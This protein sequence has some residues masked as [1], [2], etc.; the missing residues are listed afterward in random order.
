MKII[1]HSFFLFVALFCLAA[2]EYSNFPSWPVMDTQGYDTVDCSGWDIPA[3]AITVREALRIGKELG[4]GNTSEETYYIKGIVT[5]FH[6]KHESAMQDYGNAQFY[7]QDNLTFKAQFYA[8][9]IYGIDGVKFDSLSQV[10]VG[11]FVVIKSKITNYSGTIETTSKG[12]AS[13]AFSTNEYA[14]PWKEYYYFQE[15]FEKGLGQWNEQVKSGDITTIWKAITEGTTNAQADSTGLSCESW[16]VSPE[17]NVGTSHKNAVNLIFSH[18]FRAKRSQDKAPDYLRVK[19]R[20]S[21][22]EWNDMA[23][24]NFGTGKRTSYMKDTLDLS[25]YANGK[26]QIAFAY[27]SDADFQAQWNVTGISVSEYKRGK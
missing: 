7:I 10:Q 20:N 14:Y 22:G 24:H 21:A 13:M 16:L 19:V 1:K 17:I 9:Q 4:A 26:I 6:S 5:E 2:C 8:Y 18:S 25:P 27:K 23:I 3:G 12:S 15:S 11:D